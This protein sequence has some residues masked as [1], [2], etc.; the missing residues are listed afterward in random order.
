MSSTSWGRSTATGCAPMAEINM[1]REVPNYLSEAGAERLV[2][3]INIQLGRRAKYANVRAEK[4]AAAGDNLTKTYVVRSDLIN[5]LTPAEY[6]ERL[7]G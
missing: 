5:G 6:L 2:M 1:S 4:A 7:N 3:M